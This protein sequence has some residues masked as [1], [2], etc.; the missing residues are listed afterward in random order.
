MGIVCLRPAH[1]CGRLLP[2]E[3]RGT[4]TRRQDVSAPVIC[5]CPRVTRKVTSKIGIQTSSNPKNPAS[6]AVL[7]P[8][9]PGARSFGTIRA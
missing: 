1:G 6:T 7:R 8:V 2:G 4:R 9:N 3:R 5:V